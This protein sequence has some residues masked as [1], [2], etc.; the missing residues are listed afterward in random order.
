MVNPILEMLSNINRPSQ[1]NLNSMIEMVKSSKNP[2]QT[3]LSIASNNN[4][5]ASVLRMLNQNGKTPK[6]TFYKMCEVKG[7]DPSNII[8]QLR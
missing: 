8:N 5:L 4:N 3:L 1:N 2:Q 6:E 7:V